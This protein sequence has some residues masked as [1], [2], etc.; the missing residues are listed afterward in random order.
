[1]KSSK[2]IEYRPSIII[3]V[4][5]SIFW[6]V[7]FSMFSLLDVNSD[8]Y[9]II[10]VIT[11][12]LYL[13]FGFD[14]I[15]QKKYLII[16]D[17]RNYRK[18]H[19]RYKRSFQELSDYFK[20]ADP[21]KMDLSKFEEKDWHSDYGI[22]LGVTDEKKL[23]KLDSIKE[24][25]IAV[26]GSPGSHKTTGIAIPSALRFEGSVLAVDIKGDIYNFCHKNRTILRFCPDLKDKNG[27][28]IAA[29]ESCHFNPF[30]H[31]KE[32]DQTERKL[33]LTNMAATL[34]PDEPGS[35]GTYF[36]VRA[37]KIFQGITQYMMFLN[38]DITFPEVLHAI[39]HPGHPE[40]V[41]IKDLPNN[42]FEWITTIMESDCLEA[43]E[44][45]SS[46]FGNN[47]KNVSGAYDSLTTALSPYSNPVLDILL[48]GKGKCISINDLEEG[49]DIYLQI[50]Q[51]NLDAYAPLFTMIFQNFMD[52]FTRRPD[53]STGI[54]NR[55]ILLLLDEF[56]Q[57]AFSY[58]SI[59]R[60]LSTLR[61]KSIVCMLIQQSISQLIY[62]Y[63]ES[64]CNSLL[65]NCNYQ[66]CLKANDLKTQE[67]F[68][69][70]FGTK[71]VL[72]ISNNISSGKGK[73]QG[74]SLQEA[75]DPVLFPEDFGDM[76]EKLTIYYDGKRIE[77]N[78]IHCYE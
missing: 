5:M 59:N 11:V 74:R 25:N 8:R 72:R 63:N 49:A 16:T 18:D 30:G 57:F 37:R 29:K 32:M 36:P 6:I 7:F 1:M 66:L 58:K 20:D 76:E 51:E 67:Y 68:S 43:A 71:K 47:E 24:A 55:P 17:G 38:Q 78:K 23:I 46:L 26:F 69:K 4:I 41:S 19:A 53:T 13:Y 73:S 48:D 3:A 52:G 2:K 60:A 21:H 12:F 28:N 64:G 50:T 27:N 35:E 22:M 15:R 10:M 42:V 34:I 77:A 44:Q 62:K 40:L 65:G 31:I 75:R 56:P 45:V 14:A 54:K 61:S 33:F 70:K 9:I 39:L